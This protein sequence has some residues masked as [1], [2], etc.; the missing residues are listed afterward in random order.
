MPFESTR[1]R[2]IIS[3]R[4]SKSLKA[5]A[6]WVYATEIVHAPGRFTSPDAS[7]QTAPSLENGSIVDVFDEKGTWRGA[8]FFSNTSCLLYTSPSPRDS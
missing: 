6:S 1:P 3:A 4:A 7:F 5:G 2:V 8:A